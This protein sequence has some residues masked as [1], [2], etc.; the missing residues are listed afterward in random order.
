MPSHAQTISEADIREFERAGA[1]CLRGLF[2]DDW[3]QRMRAAI[4]RRIQKGPGSLS[5]KQAAFSFTELFMAKSDPEFRDFV[6]DSPAASIAAQLMRSNGVRFYFDQIFNKEPGMEEPSPWHNDQ[7][8][9]PVQGRQVCSVWLAL[10]PV[11]KETSGLQYVAGSHLQE[12]NAGGYT[13]GTVAD[14]AELLCWNMQ[15]G[16]CLVHG[17]YTVHG[18]SGNTST[19]TRRR[20]LATRWI[21][22]DVTYKVLESARTE[23][24]VPGLATG[25]I[26]PAGEPFPEVALT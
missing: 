4:E 11:T 3:V 5:R 22:D 12:E 14:Q 16:D 13:A 24:Q 1:I 26:I 25:E 7:P 9:Y 8:F 23:L 10:D 6:F 2:D 15:P 19:H 18:A 17:G 21:G 20:A